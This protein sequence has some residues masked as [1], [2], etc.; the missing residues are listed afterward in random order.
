M[1]SGIESARAVLPSRMMALWR[2][3]LSVEWLMRFLA[4]L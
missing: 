1:S 3:W 4:V 2:S